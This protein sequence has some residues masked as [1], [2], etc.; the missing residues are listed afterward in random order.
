MIQFGLLKCKMK[1]LFF[2]LLFVNSSFAQKKTFKLPQI[3]NEISGIEQLNDSILVAINDSGD[4]SNLYLINL[5]GE[6]LKTVKVSNA[7]NIDWEDLTR[8]ETHLFI[9]D[10]GNN[11]NKRKDLCIYSVLIDD[12]LSK[13]TVDAT[14][15]S[16]SYADQKE[17][18]PKESH[19]FY[20][21][22]A[23]VN[24]ENKLYVFTKDRS[25]PFQ[26]KTLVYQIPKKGGQ[27]HPS[28]SII[29][30]KNTWREDC[31]TAGD[32]FKDT[33]YLQTYNRIV[34]YRK[35]SKGFEYVGQMKTGRTQKESILVNDSA[36][37]SAD[38]YHRILGGRKL[39]VW[40]K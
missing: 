2:F 5:R 8:N 38:E 23:L 13:E 40:K 17:F 21:A 16:F 6:L 34:M 4:K 11:R 19:L 29:I 39:Y 18:P 9:A 20:D 36:I 26:G 27:I 31:I 10:I 24:I 1:Q 33:L 15:I 14:K 28:D 7:T 3:L 12:I 25:V 37:I 22:E 35:S 30:G 32:F